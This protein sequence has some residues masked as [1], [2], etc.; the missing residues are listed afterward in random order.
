MTL[1]IS[2]FWCDF[3]FYKLCNK[4][5]HEVKKNPS[6]YSEVDKFLSSELAQQVVNNFTNRFGLKSGDLNICK[7]F[8]TKSLRNLR[9]YNRRL[10]GNWCGDP[11]VHNGE[12]SD[13]SCNLIQSVTKFST[14]MTI[15]NFV[16][17]QGYLKIFLFEFIN[18]EHS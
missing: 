6:T 2:S 11:Y 13:F 3:Q 15:E 1:I 5:R 8:A 10:L 7:I 4:W 16:T 14:T 12:L 9:K 17:F 18:K